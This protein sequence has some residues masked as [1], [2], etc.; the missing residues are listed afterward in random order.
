MAI[1][2][3]RILNVHACAKGVFK[4]LAWCKAYGPCS[5]ILSGRGGGGLNVSQLFLFFFFFFGGGGG[6]GGGGG[7]QLLPLENLSFSYSQLPEGGSE[8]NK[9]GIDTNMQRLK[10]NVFTT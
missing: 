10:H 3:L 4:I 1:H 7:V 5:K 9:Q 8:I 6:G 2:I